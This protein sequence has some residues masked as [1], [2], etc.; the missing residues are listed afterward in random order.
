VL[1]KPFAPGLTTNL[2]IT[3]DRRSY[4]LQLD[5]TEKTAMTAISWTYASDQLTTLRRQNAVAEA[6]LPVASNLALEN[7]RF[8]HAITGDNPPWKP[9]RTFDDGTRSISS[10][11]AASIR[12]KPRRCLWW[13]RTTAANSSITACAAITTSLTAS[14]P[15]PNCA[16]GPN[17]NR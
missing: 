9:V 5:S 16:S 2:V 10:F 13:A 14:L 8:R 3:T 17:R 7:I 1:V 4:H 11:P 15:P 12:A 6:A